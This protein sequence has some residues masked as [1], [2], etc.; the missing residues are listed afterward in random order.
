MRSSSG[1][2]SSTLRLHAPVGG[3]RRAPRAGLALLLNRAVLG[4]SV[5]GP[6]RLP[7]DGGAVV[8]SIMI[9][10]IF[11]D[12]FGVANAILGAL[13]VAPVACWSTPRSA[14]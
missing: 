6:H 11:N 7:L 2:S 8:A 13:G 14:C 9:A 10:W 12:Q 1:S 3:R 5:R 4:A